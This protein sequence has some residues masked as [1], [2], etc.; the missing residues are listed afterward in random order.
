MK[1]VNLQELVQ[2]LQEHADGDQVV[3]QMIKKFCEN[4]NNLETLIQNKQNEK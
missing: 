3:T 4:I 2:V 1:L